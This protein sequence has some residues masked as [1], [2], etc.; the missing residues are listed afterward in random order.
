MT[1]QLNSQPVT[2]IARENRHEV[3]VETT[4]GRVLRVFKAGLSTTAPTGTVATRG[5]RIDNSR[6]TDGAR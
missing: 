1:Y 3:W 2:I 4:D 6:G 5:L